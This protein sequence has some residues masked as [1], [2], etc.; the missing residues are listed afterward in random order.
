MIFNSGS[1]GR[2][3]VQ[4]YYTVVRHHFLYVQCIIWG[5]IY[6]PM[7]SDTQLRPWSSLKKY[8]LEHTLHATVCATAQLLLVSNSI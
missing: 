5:G 1:K 7:D 3:G 2:G 6:S 4:W 8:Y